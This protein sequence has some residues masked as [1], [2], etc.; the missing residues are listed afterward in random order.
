MRC[1]GLHDALQP[2][3]VDAELQRDRCAGDS[4]DLLVLHLRFRFLADGGRQVSVVDE[5]DV[6]F[7]AMLGNLP[8]RCGDILRFLAGIGE[9]QT[10]FVLDAVVHIFKS[11]IE[12]GAGIG[13]LRMLHCVFGLVVAVILNI[14]ML[15]AEP[16]AVFLS[17]DDRCIGFASGAGTEPVYGN[18]QIADRCRQT[19]AARMVTDQPS[20]PA[21]LTDDL[22]A[23]VGTRQNVDFID[24]DIPQVGKQTDDVVGAVHQHRFQRFRR[25]LQNA[26]RVLQ[27]LIFVG[28]RNVTV[29][30]R[31]GNA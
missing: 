15:H 21:E 27:E 8:H 19:D 26:L 30:V 18:R 28:C 12:H 9:D 2:S 25:D 3:D 7:S 22:V 24:D 14:E 11:G 4:V 13:L 31:N 29:P 10:F 6:R 20:E 5:E 1:A 23:A 16:P 17:A